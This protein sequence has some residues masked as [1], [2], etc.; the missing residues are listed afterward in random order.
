MVFGATVQG[1]IN[2]LNYEFLVVIAVGSI[3]GITAGYYLNGALM[4]SIWEY[5]TELTA[6]TFSIPVIINFTVSVITI[7]RKVHYAATRNPVDSLRYE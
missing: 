5:S 7:S 2:K 1:V 6:I 4:S 3:V